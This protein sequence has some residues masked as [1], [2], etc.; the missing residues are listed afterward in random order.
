MA[1]WGVD[2]P[3][4]GGNMAQ[5]NMKVTSKVF[6]DAVKY[7]KKNGI[8]GR[9]VIYVDHLSLSRTTVGN[10]L[11]A[12]RQ[13]KD[14]SQ[15]YDA[16]KFYQTGPAVKVEPKKECKC[17]DKLATQLKIMTAQ[18]DKALRDKEELI[19]GNEKLRN[20]IKKI[21]NESNTNKIR[22]ERAQ[23]DNEQFYNRLKT[24]S[25]IIDHLKNLATVMTVVAAVLLIT[26]VLGVFAW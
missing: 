14:I 8:K 18:R 3:N 7:I 26:T 20:N 11:R 19:K 13:S 22:L 23:K 25:L 24:N 15:Q 1:R 16:F 5:N 21:L 9:T 2:K 6:E 10:I 12:M 4:K 17:D